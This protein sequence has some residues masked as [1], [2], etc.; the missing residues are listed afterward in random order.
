[1]NVY[2]LKGMDRLEENQKPIK[3]FTN[4][5]TSINL[6]EFNNND[7]LLAIGSKWKKNGL[8]LV[9]LDSLTVYENFPNIKNNVK[10]PF[11]CAFS[12]DTYMS[13]NDNNVSENIC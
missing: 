3:S 13:T 8:R 7:E 6:V 5:T 4:L 11:C 2:D 9:H 12:N 1:M 10:Y